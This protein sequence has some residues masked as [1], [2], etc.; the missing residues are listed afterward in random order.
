METLLYLSVAVMGLGVLALFMPVKVYFLADGGTVKGFE[1]SGKVMFFS[2]T[3]GGG[4]HYFEKI[5]HAHMFLFSWKVFDIDI[6]SIVGYISRKTKK[7]PL[8]GEKKE[9]KEKQPH[10]DRLRTFYRKKAV[11]WGY[12]TKG[13]HDF[14]D[15]IRCDQF[16][17]HVKLGLGNPFVTGWIV[18]MI[19]THNN[20]LPK[21]CVIAPSWDFT[22]QIVQ[23]NVSLSLTFV[24][25]KFWKN[26]ICY[27]P[28]IIR[29]VIEYKK[30]LRSPI[31]QEV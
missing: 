12:F 28:E 24:S 9:K 21:S 13:L 19:Y 27:M 20:I 1:V 26:F 23:G 5:Y 2:G 10:F 6:T 15:M 3:V 4:L 7:K 29:K 17:A 16:S 31:T 8:I 25:L 18:G 22:R 14:S 30:H 11:Y